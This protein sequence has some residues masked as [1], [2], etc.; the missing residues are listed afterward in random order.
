MFHGFHFSF[1]QKVGFCF[2]AF[3]AAAAVPDGKRQLTQKLGQISEKAGD[4]LKQD[5]FFSTWQR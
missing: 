1:K 4:T 2:L 5:F 3:A